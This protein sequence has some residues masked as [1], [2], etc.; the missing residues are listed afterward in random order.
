VNARIRE[1]AEVITR[2]MT[3]EAAVE[4]GAMALFGEKYGEEVRDVGMGHDPAPAEKH[5]VRLWL[6]STR[7][8][9]A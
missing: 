2:L 6:T 9:K 7:W 5:G 8:K 3:P 1:N 4:A